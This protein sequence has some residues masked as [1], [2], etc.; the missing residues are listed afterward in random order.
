[1]KFHEN[2]GPLEPN[3]I[4]NTDSYKPSHHLQ[5][6]KGTTRAFYFHESRGGAFDETVFFGLQAELKRYFAGPVVTQDKIDEAD[7][8]FAAHFQNPNIFNRAGWQLLLDDLGGYLP[9]EIRAVPEGTVMPVKNAL[10]T[11][12]NTDPRFEW[13]PGYL[14]TPLVRNWYPTTVASQGRVM[15]ADILRYLEETGTPEDID[16]KLH[17]FGARGSTSLEAAGIGGAAHL[18]HFKGS[19]TLEALRVLRRYYHERMAGFSIPAA[20]HS[21]IT[22]WGRKG[23]VEGLRNL[24]TVFPT[25]L[26]AG[27]SD[28]YDIF[29]CCRNIWG[30]ALREQ[31]LNREGVTIIRP[32]SG[33]PVM[34]L[35]EVL[36]ILGERFG[37]TENGKGY[38]VINPKVR[39]IQGDGI[40]RFS[41]VVILEAL[42]RADWSA[43][44]LGFGSGGGLLQK[45][46]RDTMKFAMK[47]SAVE[48]DGVWHD[49]YK[50]P[51][52]DP[53]KRSKKG[54]LALRRDEAGYR[55]DRVE[56][57]ADLDRDNLLA[58]VFR[59]G[60]V[61]V[62]QTFAD[63]RARALLAA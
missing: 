62:D 41:D 39:I 49:V 44:N 1:M 19:D 58:P 4:F 55:T 47:C 60:Q 8:L 42:K 35:L 51:V 53:G 12:V 25:G 2:Y 17:D 20:E 32:D 38:K 43:D 16:F 50:D 23:E 13:L 24:L 9:L 34:V 30:G 48:I 63:I 40:D 46:D 56:R 61:L 18:V 11:T 10:F 6:P 22:P 31:V 21:T 27:I 54:L 29:E 5:R 26:V 52:T 33:D 28:S 57:F 59:N 45:L 36:K 15:R 14:E 37:L 7:E 3:I